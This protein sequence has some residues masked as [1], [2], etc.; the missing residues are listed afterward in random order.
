MKRKKR[1]SQLQTLRRESE[2]ATLVRD[3]EEAIIELEMLSHIHRLK[4]KL[5]KNSPTYIG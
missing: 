3:R 1:L 4:K 2:I 5:G